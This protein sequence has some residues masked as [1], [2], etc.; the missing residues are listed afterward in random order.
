MGAWNDRKAGLD[1][2]IYL[3]YATFGARSSIERALYGVTSDKR[4][5]LFKLAATVLVKFLCDCST[6]SRSG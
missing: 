2:K 5:L 4:S 6:I 1:R 3:D